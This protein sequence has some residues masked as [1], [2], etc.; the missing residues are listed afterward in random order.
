MMEQKR[1][2]VT[3]VIYQ[4]KEN[5]YS[6]VNAESENE[7]FTAVGCFNGPVSGREFVLR[8]SFK[9]HPVYGEQFSFSEFEEVM[10]SSA[11]GME[12]F[13]SSG[14]LKGIGKKTAQAIVKKFGAET[15][16]IIEEHPGRL[17]E[18]D[19][20]GEKKA[21]AIASAFI[22]HR[23]FAEI[24]L[25]FQQF[26]ISSDYA[27]KLYK[28]YGADTIKKVNNNPYK[29]V[30]DVFGISFRKADGIAEK[31]GVPRDDEER[32]KSG[33]VYTLWNHIND[34]HTF[35]PK[36]VLCEKA[37]ELMD[38]SHEQITDVLVQMVFEG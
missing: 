32:I 18:V 22:A 21:E 17:T 25:Y 13:L 27:M 11:E 28:V 6:V 29:L 9:T 30:S 8:G 4:N 14:I 5:G 1:V 20:I 24:V 36:P 26:G 2:K 38:I 3:E 12:N 19:G 15:F 34:G 16:E 23:E 35:L 7:R 10:P 31:L 37:A 33:V